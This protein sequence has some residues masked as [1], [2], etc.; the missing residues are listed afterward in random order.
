MKPQ[1]FLARYQGSWE[2]LITGYL[3]ARC[4]SSFLREKRFQGCLSLCNP[5]KKSVIGLA[6]RSSP[7]VDSWVVCVVG[8]GLEVKTDVNSFFYFKILFDS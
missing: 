2:G 3:L 1:N 7:S 8:W 4:R 6:S 5:G